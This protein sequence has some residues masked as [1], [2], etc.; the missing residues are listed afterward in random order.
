MQNNNISI[1]DF[2]TH[3]LEI[4]AKLQAGNKALVITKHD[5]AVAKIEAIKQDDASIFGLMKDR[6]KI[7]GD[8]I[9]PIDEEWSCENE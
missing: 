2:K 4:I 7:K 1:T 5:K 9:N 8:I 6:M 3:C